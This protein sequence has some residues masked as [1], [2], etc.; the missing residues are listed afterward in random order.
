MPIGTFN[1][2]L[3]IKGKNSFFRLHSMCSKNIYWVN[4]R[5]NAEAFFSQGKG[6]LLGSLETMPRVGPILHNDLAQNTA[7]Q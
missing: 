6:S 1:V 2:L 5:I 4:K 7:E 3:G